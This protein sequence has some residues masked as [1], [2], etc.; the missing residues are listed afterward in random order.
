MIVRARPMAFAVVPAV[1]AVTVTVGVP[2]VL[3]VTPVEAEEQAL[4]ASARLVARPDVVE[5]T[6]KLAALLGVVHE[7]DVPIVPA[8]TVLVLAHEKVVSAPPTVKVL[9]V[10]SS[11]SMTVSVLPP[12]LAV[13]PVVAEEQALIAAARF[14][15]RVEVLR[16]RSSSKCRDARSAFRKR[17]TW[18][19]PSPN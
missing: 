17:R 6:K 4:I 5:S 11:V 8:V 2:V 3:A 12:P 9:E 14:V 13:T 18:P 19:G 7:V 10:P 15:A 16:G 1:A